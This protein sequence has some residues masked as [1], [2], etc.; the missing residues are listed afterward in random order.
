MCRDAQHMLSFHFAEQPPGGWST[1]NLS[2]WDSKEK[3]AAEWAVCE[4]ASHKQTK[5]KRRGKKFNGVRITEI[6]PSV[7][8]IN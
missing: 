7:L 2:P 5:N 8:T 1:A 6:L 3:D 4:L